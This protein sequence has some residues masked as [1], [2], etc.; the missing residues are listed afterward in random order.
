METIPDKSKPLATDSPGSSLSDPDPSQ[1]SCDGVPPLSGAEADSPAIA[2]SDSLA[3][4][5]ILRR[6]GPVGPLAVVAATMPAISGLVLLG[7]LKWT[8][9]W[10]QSQGDLGLAIYVV[11]FAVCAGLALL[12][13]YAQSVMGGW[14][15]GRLAGSTA[16]MTGIVVGSLL[17]YLVARRAAGDRVVRLIGEQPKWKAVCDALIGGSFWKTL[18]IITLLR[19]PPN[20]PFAMTNLVLAAT[21]VH[22]VAYGLGTLIGLAPRTIIATL[23][24]AQL[25]EL[26]FS[27]RGQTWFWV[28]GIVV[29]LIVIGI[30]GTLANQA[31]ARVTAPTSPEVDVDQ[32]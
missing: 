23:I 10:L 6:L 29:A 4:R 24:G 17:A 21:R 9:H 31:I 28:G 5:V 16:A 22:P 25:S 27:N 13:T 3:L 30:I 32:R 11:G 7:S 18:L 12:P 1:N 20:S 26:D 19:I 14:A 8:G 15:F 2:G